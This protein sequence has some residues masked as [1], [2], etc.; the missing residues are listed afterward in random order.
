MQSRLKKYLRLTAE[1]RRLF[2]EAYWTLGIMR[3]AMLVR[4]FKT[5]IR[6]LHQSDRVPKEET[7]SEKERKTA[8]LI[9]QAIA[10]AA[11]QTPWE[12]ACLVQALAAMRMFRR[13]GLPGHFCLGV[14]REKEETSMQAHAWMCCSE[15]F[16]T[17]RKGHKNFTI[18]SVFSWPTIDP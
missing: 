15:H 2:W 3:A 8:I 13:R 16:I 14:R 7:L 6:D 12:S 4:P 5:L 18:L 1:E 11:G 9:S 10:R 17:G